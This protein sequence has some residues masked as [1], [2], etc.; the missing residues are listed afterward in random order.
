MIVPLVL[1]RTIAYVEI[2]KSVIEKAFNYKTHAVYLQFLLTQVAF[3]A[4]FKR[5][6]TKNS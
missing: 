3:P 1:K 5:V 2:T 6:L 4:S